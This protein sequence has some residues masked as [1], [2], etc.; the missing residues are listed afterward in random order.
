M[1]VGWSSTT[2]TLT[3]K[4]IPNG[5]FLGDKIAS[6]GNTQHFL[7]HFHKKHVSHPIKLLAAMAEFSKFVP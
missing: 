7:L 1:P 2:N 4:T 5:H 6:S 3:T